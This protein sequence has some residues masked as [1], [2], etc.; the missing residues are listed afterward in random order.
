MS[1]PQSSAVRRATATLSS[2]EA[3][4]STITSATGQVWANTEA[5]RRSMKRA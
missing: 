4:S 5:S 3:S 2:V 1:R